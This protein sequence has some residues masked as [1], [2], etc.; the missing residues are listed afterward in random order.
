MNA[1]VKRKSGAFNESGGD[2]RFTRSRHSP[3]NNTT[4]DQRKR[5]QSGRKENGASTS[6][7]RRTQSRTNDDAGRNDRKL[8]VPLAE[9]GESEL[10]QNRESAPRS[11]TKGSKPLDNS[12]KD[13]PANDPPKR[14]ESIDTM[15]VE[16]E[17]DKLL[18][19]RRLPD[20][21]IELLVKWAD[22]SEEATFEPEE[23][24]QNGAADAL[25]EY[26]GTQGGRT[27]ALFRT[28]D[29]S[30]PESYYVFTI[31]GHE[32][33]K[34][35]FIL[36]VQWVGYPATRAHTTMEAESK[37]KNVCPDL[38]HEYWER[39]G[40]RSKHLAKRGRPRANR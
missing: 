21:R 26:W 25:Y 15:E 34:K 7:S 27:Q 12:E 1:S 5:G 13:H 2:A 3:T 28:G 20:S 23:E 40:G 35:G 29:S 30:F 16:K 24:I 17:L 39:K 10:F 22:A 6:A 38:L 8:V 37:L 31:L 4:Q 36:E 9:M 14:V 19:H 11:I 32:K 33:H 18:G